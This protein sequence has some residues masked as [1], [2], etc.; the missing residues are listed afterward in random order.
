MEEKMF[1][2]LNF[3]TTEKMGFVDLTDQINDAIKESGVREG[4]CYVFTQHSTGAIIIS[5]A[6]DDIT[7]DLK[8]EMNRLVPLRADFNHSIDPATDAAGHIKSV[9]FGVDKFTLIHEGKAMLGHAQH[10]LFAEFDG[11]RDREVYVKVIEG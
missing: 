2:T 8:F 9:M 4:V 3:K 5:P 7:A 10:F 11:P 6:F 1:K